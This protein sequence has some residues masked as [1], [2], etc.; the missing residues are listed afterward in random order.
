[1]RRSIKFRSKLGHHQS[2]SIQSAEKVSSSAG[3]KLKMIISNIDT[4]YQLKYGMD[5]N[6]FLDA[7]DQVL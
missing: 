2:G 5:F 3:L 7:R 4:R 1:M 6:N